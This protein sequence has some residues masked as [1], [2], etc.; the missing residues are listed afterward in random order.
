M[1]AGAVGPRAG[2]DLLTRAMRT[3]HHLACT[4]GEDIGVVIPLPRDGI[5]VGREGT[6]PLSDARASRVH[7]RVCG[8]EDAD[9]PRGG[10]AWV[11]RVED[12]SSTNGVRI[13]RRGAPRPLPDKLRPGGEALLRE[14][15]VVLL[16]GDAFE[17]RARPRELTWTPPPP[18]RHRSRLRGFLVVPALLVVSSLLWRRGGALPA[19]TWIAVATVAF[20]LLM[21]AL[22]RWRVTRGRW[23]RLDAAHLALVTRAPRRAHTP[24]VAALWMDRP[25]GARP[26]RRWGHHAP[27]RAGTARGG[28]S[29]V[30][31]LKAG[32]E[33]G[34]G[35]GAPGGVGSIGVNA[36]GHEA[37]ASPRRLRRSDVVL[38][39]HVPTGGS[40][41][42]VPPETFSPGAQTPATVAEAPAAMGPAASLVARWW[43]AQLAMHAGGATLT[44]EDGEVRRIGAGALAIHL[45]TGEECP[46][47]AGGAPP[48]TTPT[49]AAPIR[50]GPQDPRDTGGTLP[51]GVPPTGTVDA[52]AAAAAAVA[53]I[54][55]GATLGD[56]PTWC[57]RVVPCRGAPVS[58]TWWNQIARVP[59][60]GHMHLPDVVRAEDLDRSRVATPGGLAAPIGVGVR[61]EVWI[62]LVEDGPHALVAGTTGSGKSEAL[63]TWLLGLCR[64]YRPEELRLVLLDYKGGATFA[65]LGRLPHCEAVLTDLDPADTE[66][67]LRGIAALLRSRERR[68]RELGL[69]DWAR[70]RRAH[71]AGDAPAPPPRV[72]IALDEFRVLADAHPRMMDALVRLASQGRSL[73]LHLVLA[74]QRP[75]GAVSAAMRAN[76]EVRLA[77]RCA[78]DADSLD[79]IGSVAAARIPR[80]PGR[81]LLRDGD[82]FQ[83]AWVDDVAGAV[84][85]IRAAETVSEAVRPG[86]FPGGASPAESTGA[87]DRVAPLWAPPLPEILT[88][89]DVAALERSAQRRP[90]ASD[91]PA[92]APA[93]AGA[94]E[95]PS[96]CEHPPTAEPPPTPVLALGMVDGIDVGAHMAWPWREGHILLEG[97][98]RDAHEL[99][100]TAL[101]LGRRIAEHLGVPLHVCSS[102]ERPPGHRA[103]WVSPSDPSSCAHLLD[104]AA[105]NGPAV[106]VLDDVDT[107]LGSLGAAIGPAAANALLTALLGSAGPTG[108]TLVVSAP[109][110]HHLPSSLPGAF[111]QRLLRIHSAEDALRRALPSTTSPTTMPGRFVVPGDPAGLPVVQVPLADTTVPIDAAATADVPHTTWWVEP[112]PVALP[113]SSNVVGGAPT[114]AGP[115]PGARPALLAGARLLPLRCARPAPWIVLGIDEGVAHAVLG[116]LHRRLGWQEDPEVVVLAAGRWTEVLTRGGHNVL[117]LGTPSDLLRALCARALTVAPGARVTPTSGQVGVVLHDDHLERVVLTEHA[118]LS[119]YHVDGSGPS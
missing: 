103:T 59:T 104:E 114:P 89:A 81:A 3:P 60:H 80:I 40:S 51:A 77:L 94:P 99:S 69:P 111:A 92:E 98:P 19:W 57:D 95:C 83:V 110:S 62:D 119:P 25:G 10:A 48:D 85:Q 84:D 61:G 97:S 15:D 33:A 29:D 54:G 67:A 17:V 115:H 34:V 101:A 42:H 53:H 78:D 52:A 50:R 109:G 72:V 68:L 65:P 31:R 6:P 66:R 30:A 74:T 70:W 2:E 28:V 90:G 7:A 58:W 117:S 38:R 14:G 36:G 73:G 9:P 118:D 39:V 63:V 88:W 32:G 106:L 49:S 23:D 102:T 18:P 21:W 113:P 79:V 64:G 116:D 12:L 87:P 47:C 96:A 11:A 82:A 5:V 43:A 76:I 55:V 13:R 16:G 56:V 75:A 8:V 26:G 22:W 24:G 107:L 86:I 27:V 112:L 37:R 100:R 108:V 1:G 46:T 44:C 105:A 20:A 91:R 71:E 93:H 4:R 41:G 45:V 35:V